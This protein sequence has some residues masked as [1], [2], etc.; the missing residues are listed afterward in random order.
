VN[1]TSDESQADGAS[2]TPAISADGR[3]VAFG[4][5][6]PNLGTAPG[7]GVY[8]R[9]LVARTTELVSV[10]TGGAAANSSSYAGVG[11]I[12]AD[13]RLVAF[14]SLGSNLVPGDT[15]DTFDVFARDRATG[16]TEL[17]SVARS[18][19]P[20]AGRLT[21]RPN[22]PRAGRS[23]TAA[24]RVSADGDPV[25]EARVSCAAKSGHKPLRAAARSFSDSTA[26]C[27]WRIPA[28]AKG[29]RLRGTVT[30]STDFG[31]ARKPFSARVR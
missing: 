1:V 18:R 6:A 9:D 29:K 31:R 21:S 27:V 12:N 11:P 14:F 20:S 10:S 17:V 13:G 23:F 4:S 2:G 8:V 16:T 5:S 3:A 22:P 30:V 26:R 24:L 15:N 25:E 19:Q 7:G 28:N